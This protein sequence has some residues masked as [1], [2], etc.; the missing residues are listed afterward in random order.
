MWKNIIAEIGTQRIASEIGM[1]N[2]MVW[3]WAKGN[4]IPTRKILP[5]LKE[6]ILKY[7]PDKY[8][9]FEISLNKDL[10]GM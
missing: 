8:Q 1:T 9:Q 2:T 7:A 4:Y 5:K 3:H 6:S 10:V